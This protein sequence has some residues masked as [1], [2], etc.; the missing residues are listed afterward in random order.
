M[1]LIR[2]EER[3]TDRNKVVIEMKDI[4]KEKLYTQNVKVYYESRL[5]EVLLVIY[6]GYAFVI[7]KDTHLL[8]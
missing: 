2:T 4:D 6:S 7:K 1:G 5:L 3:K 8:F